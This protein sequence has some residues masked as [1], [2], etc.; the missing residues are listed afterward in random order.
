[1]PTSRTA[2]IKNAHGIHCRPSAAIIKAVQVWPD[3]D[4]CV[5]ATSGESDLRSIFG[6]IALG[7]TPNSKV[8]IAVSGNEEAEICDELVTLFE[9]HFDFPPEG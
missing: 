1:M 8:S 3:V 4:I 7:L 2:I 6:L 5:T 9:T